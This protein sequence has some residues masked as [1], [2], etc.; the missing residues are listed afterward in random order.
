MITFNVTKK[1]S[2]LHRLR[3]T[4][5]LVDDDVAILNDLTIYD[6]IIFGL[7]KA[8]NFSP[9]KYESLYSEISFQKKAKRFKPDIIH[10]WPVYCHQYVKKQREKNQLSTLADVY[11]AHPEHTIKMLAPVYDEFGLDIKDSYFYQDASR[12]TEFLAHENFIVV[13]SQYV[14]ETFQQKNLLKDIFVAEYGFWGDPDALT[15]YLAASKHRHQLN[16]ITLKLVYVGSVSLEKGVPYLLEAMKRL[17]SASIQLDI[18]GSVKKSQEKIFNKY[19]SLASVKFLGPRPNSE[20]KNLLKNYSA[21]VLPSLTDAYSISVIEGLQQ[22]LPVIVSDQTGNKDD[23]KKFN[24]GEIVIAANT[25]SLMIAIEKMVNAEYMGF[26]SDN[27]QNFIKNDIEDPYPEK[28][29]RIYHQLISKNK[30]VD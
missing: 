17:A 24:T 10:Y 23:V 20:I 13:N 9:F 11:S 21:L 27:I 15:N 18:I 12:N 22:A 1:G 2:L 25:D 19:H 5:R 7:A 26:L 6:Q 30:R 16:N 8:F 29:L 14:K 4:T 28:V 3:K